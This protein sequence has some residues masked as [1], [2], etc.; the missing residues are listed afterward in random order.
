MSGSP[1]SELSAKIAERI[2]CE[3]PLPF[4]E[5]MSEAL[6]APHLGYYARHDKSPREDYYT[7]P[8]AH[9]AFGALMA[10]WAESSWRMMGT[11]EFS[12][13][14]MGAGEGVLARDFTNYVQNNLIPFGKSL[15]YG[16]FDLCP[17][18]SPTKIFDVLPNE[19]MPHNT[20]GLVI[21]NELLDALPFHIFE[22]Y[23]R[24]PME[25]FIENDG[26]GFR[27]IIG[28]PS[29]DIIQERLKDVISALPEGYRGEVCSYLGAWSSQ[30]ASI[31][32]KGL[33]IVFDYGAE[34]AS[35]YSPHRK[36]GTILSFRKH[37]SELSYLEA[38]GEK[39]I[40]A[41]VDFT[42]VRNQLK[43]K[44]FEHCFTMPQG[45]FLA[46]MGLE[47]WLGEIHSLGLHE[48][49]R[50]A[51]KAGVRKLL[52]KEFFGGFMVSAFRKGVPVPNINIDK[53]HTL[54]LIEEGDATHLN[55]LDTWGRFT[56]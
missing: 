35:L 54:P 45:E 46:E 21:A 47:N 3:G 43:G 51:N 31:V 36:D 55:A 48:Q 38:P 26:P 9:P 29:S 24:K 41:H 20:H 19:K 15:K 23:D 42:E 49:A 13:T 4:T 37:T 30:V 12:V 16:A 44:G 25:V 14:E 1:R 28:D 32:K 18:S 39:D 5:Y 6:Y 22:V 8:A 11:G 33:V 53:R 50:L 27:E 7:A 10:I 56:D 2:R 40:T 52:G 34:R 17:K